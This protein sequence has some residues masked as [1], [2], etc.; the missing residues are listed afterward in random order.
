V[1]LARQLLDL[2]VEPGGV[3]LVHTSYR[4]I[5]PVVGGPEGLILALREALGPDGTLVMP[6]WA[7]DGDRPFHPAS[8]PADVDLGVVARTFWRLPDVQRS[9][10]PFAFAA[11][12]PRAEEV[13][14]DGLPLPPH[15]PES[16]V[17]RV[18]DLDGHVL[19]LGVDHDAD[20]TVHLAELEAGVPY[21]LLKTTTVE[22]DGRSVRVGYGEN[23]HC[24]ARFTC[25]GEWLDARDLQRVGPVG[26]GT[27]RLIRSRDVVS[28][29]VERLTPD[30]TFFLHPMGSGC[31]ECDEAWSSIPSDWTADG[32]ARRRH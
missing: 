31:E 10:H 27:A 16:P 28:T 12:G 1:N 19:L 24:C 6:S 7:A 25:V 32:S 3:L 5:R 26:H 20:T 2:G 14:A 29:V 30:P 22:Q 11:A 9:R 8:S 13:L 21:R 18:R 17:G 23:D 15:R 4:A